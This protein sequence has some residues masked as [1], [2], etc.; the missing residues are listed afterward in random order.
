MRTG[1]VREV[2]SWIDS[3]APFSTQE[4]YDNSGLLIGSLDSLVE[5]VLLALDATPS[6]VAEALELGAKLIVVHHPLMFHPIQS[7]AEPEYEA[8]VISLL[9][10]EKIALLAAHTN[11]DRSDFS[12]SAAVAA[13]LGLK[14]SFREGDY[15]HVGSLP[16][17]LRADSLRTRVSRLLGGP[18]ILYGRRDANVRM[19]AIGGGALGEAYVQARAAGADALLTGEARHHEAVAAAESGFVLLCGGHFYTEAPMLPL[20]AA[21]LQAA[22]DTLQYE[23]R[24]HVST[25]DPYKPGMPEGG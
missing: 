16:R 8:G 6:V 23:M 4:A 12:G 1:T 11:F 19:L 22:M 2:F 20:V 3:V 17:P 25:R 14:N 18:A 21:G 13:I 5:T 24:I 15:L 9:I 10:R 7:L